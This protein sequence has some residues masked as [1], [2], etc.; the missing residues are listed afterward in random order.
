MQEPA[1]V[2]PFVARRVRRQ[3]PAGLLELPSASDLVLPLLLKP[4]DYG[5][6][7]ALVEVAL[8]G[9]SAAPDRL[10]CFVGLEELA[11]SSQLETALVVCLG[12]RLERSKALLAR[13]KQ[14]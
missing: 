1:H 7:E 2:E 11:A 4:G 13:S 6:D 5:V 14:W 3:P 10:E 8:A 9:V 12:H